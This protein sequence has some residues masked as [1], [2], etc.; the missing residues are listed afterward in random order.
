MKTKKRE[1][2]KVFKLAEYVCVNKMVNNVF[3][4]IKADFRSFAEQCSL[5]NELPQ[6][7]CMVATV[8]LQHAPQIFG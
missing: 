8:N 3:N 5:N 6:E 2:L 1:L 4:F 7:N